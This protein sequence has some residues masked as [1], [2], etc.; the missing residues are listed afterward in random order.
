[1]FA[2]SL[3]DVSVELPTSSPKLMPV[4]PVAAPPVVPPPVELAA[5]PVVPPPPVCAPPSVD[6]PLGGASPGALLDC[7]GSLPVD[8]DEVVGAL[9]LLPAVVIELDPSLIPGGVA[10]AGA[11]TVLLRGVVARTGAGGRGWLT[12]TMMSPNCSG[13]RSRPMVLIG[14]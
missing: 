14:S 11:P 3:A 10:R 4:E 7:V 13:V 12:F 1:M 8:A 5:P 6:T 2:A 9:L